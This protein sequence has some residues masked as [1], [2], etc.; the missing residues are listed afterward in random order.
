MPTITDVALAA[1]VSLSTVS[2]VLNG[3]RHASVE[4]THRVKAA[5]AAVGHVPNAA[6]RSLRVSSTRAIGLAISTI[7]SPYFADIVCAI[8]T[9]CARLGLMVFLAGTEDDPT[10]ELAVVRALHAR[11]VE[12][13]ILAPSAD[14]SAALDHVSRHAFPC[15]LVDRMADSRFDQVGVDN[16]GATDGLVRHLLDAG[17]RRIAFIG[18]HPG[19]ATTEARADAF[20]AT[21]ATAGVAIDPRWSEARARTDADVAAAF[22]RLLDAPEP[23]TALVAGSNLVTIAALRVLRSR[24][25]TVP[26]DVSLVGIDDFDWADCFEPRLTLVAQPCAEIGRQAAVLLVERIRDPEA[27]LRKVALASELRVRGSV[28]R[29]A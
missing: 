17:H 15:V 9:Q 20:R 8:E 24:G 6:A 11:Q 16:A 19:F 27:P 2:H 13:I 18:G 14:P 10:R 7:A 26:R 23:P 21:L 1:G 12:G 25:L 22:T 29:P 28:G 5:V 3:T 4:K